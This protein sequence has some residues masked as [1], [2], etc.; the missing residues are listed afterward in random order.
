[1]LFIDSHCH[2]DQLNYSKLY[3]NIDDLFKKAYNNHVKLFLSVSTSLKNFQN[4]LKLFPNQKNILYSCGIHPL[5]CDLEIIDLIKLKRFSMYNQVIA[6][7]ETGLDYYYQKN[8]KKPQ[9]YLFRKHIQ[10]AKSIQKPIIVH[11]RQAKEDTIKILQEENAQFCQGILHSFSEDV[12]FAKKLL[13]IGFYIS[14][15]GM[16]TFKNSDIIR[17]VLK[18]IPIDSLLIETDSPYL[19]P[20]P[21]RGQENQ[22]S[23][24]YDIAK[25]ISCQKKINIEYLSEITTNNFCKLFNINISEILK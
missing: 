22:P 25:Y 3:K 5:N 23:Y 13:D 4:L 6:I 12:Q 11:S 16:I 1:M 2:L 9:Q 19:T 21:Y 24:L 18:Y 8:K 17:K 10:I 20:V 14:F 15:S 7:G